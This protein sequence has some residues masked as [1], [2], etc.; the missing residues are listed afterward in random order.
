[1]QLSVDFLYLYTPDHPI[2]FSG[3]RKV[4]Q[5]KLDALVARSDFISVNALS[6]AYLNYFL[7]PVR[8]PKSKTLYFLPLILVLL[9]FLTITAYAGISEKSDSLELRLKR[10]EGKARLEVLNELAM[11]LCAI[12]P[13][14]GITYGEQAYELAVRLK[15]E[16]SQA[17]AMES[18]GWGCFNIYEFD[19]AAQYLTSSLELYIKLKVRDKIGRTAQNAGLAY[20]QSTDYVKAESYL[21][22]AAEEFLSYHDQN[23]LAYCYINLGLVNYMKSEYATALDYFGKASEIYKEIND[24]EKYS[25]LLNRIGMTYWSL[26]INDKALKYLLESN[27]MKSKDDPKSIA[28]G[29][30]NIGAIYKALGD[31][32]KA[33]GF[34]QKAFSCYE[35][36][37]DSLDMPSPLNNIG[38]IYAGRG[39]YEKALTYYEEALQISMAVRDNLQT[40][41]T[42]HNIGLIYLETGQIDKAEEFFQEFL[43][44]SRQIGNKEGIAH[45]LLSL[46]DVCKKRGAYEE[47]RHYL[48]Q[49]IS[50]SDSI[51]YLQVLKSAHLTM[52]EMLEEIGMNKEALYHYQK[53]T[54]VKDTLY[55]ADKARI[56][57]EIQTKYEVTKKQQENDLLIKDNELKGRKIKTL[58][59]I[60]GGFI[61]LVLVTIL[62]IVQYGKTALNKKKL[63]ESEAARLAEKVDHQNRELASSAL[64]LSRNFSFINKLVIDLK[65]ISTHTD[66]D[67]IS[68]ILSVTRNIQH[69]ESDSAWK[70]FEMRF[71]EVHTRFYESLRNAYP[72][73]T[74][75][76]V[77]LCA[78]LKLGMSTKEIS[79][80]TFQNIRALEAAR[81]RLRKKLS[82]E[83]SDDLSAFLQRY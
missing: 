20:L 31:I 73:L 27:A 37:G 44:I 2:K 74:S 30:N 66:E 29:Y 63:A 11:E 6:L 67:G 54:Q 8:K 55:N 62:L 16:R 22:L 28:I 72:T 34:Y 81:L 50:L 83:G 32:E 26:G 15:D 46:G 43:N 79:V 53:Y 1:M 21:L 9:V 49:C 25:E 5:Y 40:A 24:P 75:N 14:K 41:K 19:K 3:F 57:S 76:E 23:R 35:D 58:F 48:A 69:L 68:A 45:A 60:F 59:L 39:E 18:I 64:A 12:D 10:S 77:R 51:Q 38:T 80:V 70:E 13:R 36:A 17:L 61:I 42:K 47:S 71:K 7:R 78:F 4:K 65:D 52:S 33:L 56:I 82:L